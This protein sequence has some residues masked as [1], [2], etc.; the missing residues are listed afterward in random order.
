MTVTDHR[1][2][3]SQSLSL[4]LEAD[5]QAPYTMKISD[6]SPT[7]RPNCDDL[8]KSVTYVAL[9]ELTN[10]P[11]ST[12]QRRVRRRPLRQDKAAKQQ[13]LTI[14]EKKALVEYILRISDNGYP[15]PVKFLCSLALIIACQRHS[16]FQI[17]LADDDIRPP[18]KNWPQGFYAR[19]P[20]LK[21]RRVK[22][23]DWT[24][25]DH[26]IYNK[27]IQWYSVIRRELQNPVIIAYNIY[28]MD[29]IGVLLSVLHSLKVLVRRD[30]VLNG[31]G[32][33][34]KRTLVT[35]I[36]CICAAGRHLPPLIIWP[37]ATHRS[38]WITHHTPSWHFTCS[39]TGYTDKEISLYQMQ[40]VFEPFTRSQ[41]QGKPRILFNDGFATHESL[42]LLKFC[43]ENNIILCRL[44][45][46]TSHKLQPRD[47]G[48]FGPLKTAYQEVERLY[49]GGANTVGK[50]HF[51]LFYS[52]ARETAF[53]SRNIKA[54]WY[55]TGLYSFNPDMVLQEI[56]KPPPESNAD[57]TII[58]QIDLPPSSNQLPTPVIA[59]SL[60]SLCRAIEQHSSVLNED[61]QRQVQKLVNAAEKAFTD[62]ALLLDENRLLFAQNNERITRLSVKVT[63]IGTAKVMSYSDIVQAQRKRNAKDQDT[64]RYTQRVRKRRMPVLTK[65]R[66]KRAK[67][68]RFEEAEKARNEIEML[69]L[70]EYCSV[71]HIDCDQMLV[72]KPRELLDVI[73]GQHETQASYTNRVS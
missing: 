43:F 72:E 53:T 71:M 66:G 24:R 22:A 19:H 11:V 48:V 7:V 55:K 64:V 69:D 25:H 8:I 1:Y 23:L 30:D 65:E 46:H 40:H 70:R 5:Q 15:L 52:R 21:A 20:E 18:G 4:I 33:G 57:S 63:V 13:Y 16:A 67:Q 31:R 56:Q 17:S 68:A 49:R 47:V 62:C 41:A 42:E 61:R 60:T 38:T 10:I 29:K 12:L 54:G 9:S 3:Q 44:P 36:E 50:Q 34:V 28:N 59:E 45:S 27:V 26:N 32:A 2:G 35:A 58:T 39:K 51:T 37:A 14:Y 6:L 73:V